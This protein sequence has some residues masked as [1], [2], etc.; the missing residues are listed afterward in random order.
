MKELTVIFFCSWKFALTFPV[1]VYS[2]NLS[3]Y[4]TLLY[5]NIGGLLGLIIFAFLSEQLIKLW[6]IHV[7][8]ILRLRSSYQVFT[9]KRRRFIHIKNN[10]GFPGIVI[11]NP[12]I[13]SIPIS[14]FLVIKYFGKKTKY[15]LWLLFGQICWSIIYTVFYFYLKPLYV[16][17]VN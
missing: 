2:M 4:E 7:K 17:S 6:H 1:A 14:T 11:L 16:L 15:F 5:T 13:L 3:L 10:Y 9:P 8:P 12:I